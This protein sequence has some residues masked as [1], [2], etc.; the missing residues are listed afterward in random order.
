MKLCVCSHNSHKIK[1]INQIIGPHYLLQ[2]LSE[3]GCHED[4]P[5]TADTFLGNALLKVRHVWQNYQLSGF[6]DDSGLCVDVLNG[7]PGVYS[8]RYAGDARQDSD[9]LKRVL[10]EIQ[11]FQEIKAR[12]VCVIALILDGQEH[13]FEGITEGC[14]LKTPRGDGGFG[15]DPIFV[16][17]GFTQTFAEM[18]ITQKNAI[19]HR[20]KALEQL[21]NFL[22]TLT[23]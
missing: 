2:S 18:P 7:A 17:N 22:D 4:I 12:F 15:Y 9:N 21:K 19:S 16:P 1:E 10:D 13:S 6:A 3:I 8:A 23:F 5:E 14:L 11:P 20:G